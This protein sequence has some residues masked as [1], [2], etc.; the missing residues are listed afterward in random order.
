MNKKQQLLLYNNSWYYPGANL[1]K[2]ALWYLI[3]AWFINSWLP[4]SRFKIFLLR[5]FGAK[6][7]KRCVIKNHVNIKYP[8]LFT[9]GDDCWI[10]E[11]VWIDNLTHVRIG[12]NVCISQ[13]AMLLTGNHNYKKESFDLMVGE[14]TLHNGVW[15]GANSTVCSNVTCFE[16]SV[17]TVG[18]VLTKNTEPYS[19]YSGIPAKKVKERIFE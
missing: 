16:Q 15:I 19:I 3:N 7:G 1:F 17:L 4:F 9:C 8:W 18:S 5:L 14:I 2:R 6:I 10:G 11:K 12:N 13:G